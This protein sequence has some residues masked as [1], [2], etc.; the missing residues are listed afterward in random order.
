[1]A[2]DAKIIMEAADSL[3]DMADI[4]GVRSTWC[5]NISDLRAGSREW[6]SEP[7]PNMPRGVCISRA[8]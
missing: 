1:M 3:P 7:E 2:I 4:G 5:G 6:A 8:G